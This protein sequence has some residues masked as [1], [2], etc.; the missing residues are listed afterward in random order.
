MIFRQKQELRRIPI[1]EKV[2]SVTGVRVLDTLDHNVPHILRNKRRACMFL[3]LTM[4]LMMKLLSMLQ[5]SLV[6][7]NPMKIHVMRISLMMNWLIPTKNFVPEVKRFVR[8][9]KSRR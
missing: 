3:A 4:N 8:Y 5:P 2:F 7:V 6:D 9:E 1:K